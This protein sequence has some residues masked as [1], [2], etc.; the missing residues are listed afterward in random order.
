MSESGVSR[1]GQPSTADE[2]RRARLAASLRENLKRRKAQSRARSAEAA[3][4]DEPAERA[5]GNPKA[6]GGQPG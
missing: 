2:R 6:E 3:S 4:S 5:P 1:D